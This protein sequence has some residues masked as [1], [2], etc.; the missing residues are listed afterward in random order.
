MCSGG[1]A[2]RRSGWTCGQKAALDDSHKPAAP[3]VAGPHP[4]CAAGPGE[5]RKAHE[6]LD[7]HLATPTSAHPRRSHL[8][9]RVS[10][11]SSLQK[12]PTLCHFAMPGGG[13][14]VVGRDQ[15]S[16][17][18]DLQYPEWCVDF[19][20]GA[21]VAL[22]GLRGRGGPMVAPTGFGPTAVRQE[23]WPGLGRAAPSTAW[24]DT[25]GNAKRT[26]GHWPSSLR[27]HVLVSIEWDL[28]RSL[29]RLRVWRFPQELGCKVAQD[30]ATSVSPR[31]PVACL[32]R[33]QGRAGEGWPPAWR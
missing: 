11:D 8:S 19:G 24:V 6:A 13:S 10:L 18:A 32:G 30:S 15:F 33:Q 29:K 28:G 16:R 23:G 31:P 7:L 1:C 17:S 4:D 26:A 20:V 25:V 5:G 9:A 22:L 21:R 14:G 3:R 12:K 2:P 27:G